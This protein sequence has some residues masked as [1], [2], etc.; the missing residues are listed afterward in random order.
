MVAAK[1][2]E[3][4]EKKTRWM[5]ERKNE[6]LY[7]SSYSSLSTPVRS[8]SSHS[9]SRT[10]SDN[11]VTSSSRESSQRQ[12]RSHL[13]QVSQEQSNNSRVSKG[14]DML[15]MTKSELAE[16]IRE[17]ISRELRNQQGQ[18]QYQQNLSSEQ[19]RGG[20]SSIGST[21]ASNYRPLIRETTMVDTAAQHR[22]L[23]QY[24]MQTEAN[25]HTC[26][27]CFELMVSPQRTPMFLYPCG[28]TFCKECMGRHT[29]QAQI[30][31][32]A[33]QAH[34]AQTY[35]QQQHGTDASIQKPRC[36]F[37]RTVI[38]SMVT[39]QAI[40][41]LIDG[42]TEQKEHLLPPIHRRSEQE[43]VDQVYEQYNAV[44]S[45]CEIRL[46]V[47][48]QE[49]LERRSEVEA[50]QVRKRKLQEGKWVGG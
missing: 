29:H 25:S 31:T 9:S 34:P 39:N 28:H 21:A 13:S 35:I 16:H 1:R 41:E 5:Q 22:N 26:K 12:S 33:H 18:R 15:H 14:D 37:C 20:S 4:E 10:S 19:N 38:Q 48:D 36:P 3:L 11:D 6:D 17:E 47:I 44:V 30:N 49:I 24:V 27:I 45:S 2:R 43:A 7:A 46:G 42:Y 32:Q 8:Q 23:E 40:K 50:Q